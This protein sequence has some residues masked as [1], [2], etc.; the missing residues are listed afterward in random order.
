[1]AY[2]QLSSPW[3]GNSQFTEVERLLNC[4]VSKQLGQGGFGTVVGVQ[5][6]HDGQFGAVKIVPCSNA[7]SGH[8]G[9]RSDRERLSSA[10]EEAK[11][12]QSLDHSNIVRSCNWV[13][14]MDV[15][16]LMELCPGGDLRSAIQRGHPL[17]LRDVLSV[18]ADLSSAL[19]YLHGRAVLHRDV[20]PANCLLKH[21]CCPGSLRLADFGIA[22]QLRRRFEPHASKYGSFGYVAPELRGSEPTVSDTVDQWSFGMVL[23]DLLSGVDAAERVHS[24]NVLQ[25]LAGHYWSWRN[26][27][28]RTI[29]ASLICEDFERRPA[30]K[31]VN[32]TLEGMAEELSCQRLALK[33]SCA[34]SCAPGVEKGA[35][36]DVIKRLGRRAEK[37]CK[38]KRH[39]PADPARNAMRNLYRAKRRRQ[40]A[41]RGL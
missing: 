26:W 23:Y 31:V 34:P 5:N 39:L 38:A 16:I 35:P 29:F 18:A 27:A 3:H 13:S 33:P 2:V 32:A 36:V 22:K 8:C 24:T 6:L 37:E 21:G 1:M 17:E 14:T 9:G 12:L 30:M 11:L 19:A 4:K 20:K 41:E 28:L 40:A 10:E 15:F 25:S 7:T